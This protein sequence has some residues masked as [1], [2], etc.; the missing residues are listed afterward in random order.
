MDYDSYIFD[1]M[2]Q[3]Y[4]KQLESYDTIYDEMLVYYRNLVDMLD[5]IEIDS[6]EYVMVSKQINELFYEMQVFENKI[7]DIEEDVNRLRK[8]EVAKLMV[9]IQYLDNYMNH[10]QEHIN[11]LYKSVDD[12]WVKTANLGF[13]KN[14]VIEMADFHNRLGDNINYFKYVLEYVNEDKNRHNKYISL[15]SNLIIAYENDIL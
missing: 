8:N 12:S 2:L 1:E 5:N 13:K 15:Y 11:Q 3:S 7:D 9:Y 6:F 4:E 14:Y 10:I